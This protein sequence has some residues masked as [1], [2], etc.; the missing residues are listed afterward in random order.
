MTD[1]ADKGVGNRKSP[2]IYLAILAIVQLVIYVFLTNLSEKFGI[3]GDHKLRPIR[4]VLVLLASAFGLHLLSLLMAIRLPDTKQLAWGV[5]G[6]AIV[7]RIVVLFSQPIQEVDIYRYI[8]DGAVANKGVSP[9]RYPPQQIA[10][11][12]GAPDRDD[13]DISRLADMVVADEGL[14]EVLRR[15]HFGQLPTVYPPISQVVFRVS[16]LLTPDGVSVDTRVFV[17]KTLIVLYD[18]GVLVLLCLLLIHVGMHR[19]WCI[20]Y[21]WSPLVI[22][23]FANSGHLDS[24][25]V[26]LMMAAV[27]ICVTRSTKFA[28]I[29]S[30][31]VLGLAFGAKLFPI[32]LAPLLGIYIWKQSGAKMMLSWCA[33]FVVV[34]GI[35]FA[36]MV[37]ARLDAPPEQMD[38]L[39]TF[40]TRWE[41]N[42]L[43]FMAVEENL[44]PEGAVAGQVPLWFAATPDRFRKSVMWSATAWTGD[45]E[46]TP[47]LL[48]RALL[49]GLFGVISLWLCY[50][51]WRTPEAI[52]ESAFLALAWFWFLAP[53]Q[54]PWYWI[55]ALPLVPFVR[56]R[57][58]LLVSG[59]TLVYYC[60]FWFEYHGGSWG[61]YHGVAL[62][63]FVIVWL[64]FAPFLLLLAV[65]RLWT[66]KKSFEKKIVE[67]STQ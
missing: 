33:G 67:E 4:L 8:W 28:I 43:V 27:V 61:P 12:A 52:C 58:W 15:V 31:I 5:I 46:R 37:L 48:T 3:D 16:D 51:V 64:E 30:S 6:I 40:L 47:F 41:I 20:T 14:H 13:G 63:D 55:W 19:A 2:L 39:K 62:F 18:I 21:G 42:D 36:P 54:N 22:K 34:A 35:S 10:L 11:A 24:I 9:Y 66:R 50:R 26:F 23:E 25:A 53:T 17:M 59:L 38:G 44:R 65:D 32:V 7:F 56:Q 57:V 45:E 49:L 60:R 29:S 1:D